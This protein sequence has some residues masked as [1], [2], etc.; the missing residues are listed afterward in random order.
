MRKAIRRNL[1]ILA[2]LLPK[3]SY[4][5]ICKARLGVNPKMGQYLWY[6]P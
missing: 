4:L 5:P 1:T 6:G 2:M 3:L